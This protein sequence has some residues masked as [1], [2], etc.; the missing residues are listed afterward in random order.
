MGAGDRSR[1]EM[2]GDRPARKVLGG[3]DAASDRQMPFLRRTAKIFTDPGE[4]MA[5]LEKQ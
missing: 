1:L 3:G 5:W 4:A 2:L